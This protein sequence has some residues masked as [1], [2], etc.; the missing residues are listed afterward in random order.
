M[1]LLGFICIHTGYNWTGSNLC[2][3]FL[4]RNGIGLRLEL[5]DSTMPHLGIFGWNT[6]GV[7]GWRGDFYTLSVLSDHIDWIE[8]NITD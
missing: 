6:E 3:L 4:G 8:L 7:L 1:S 5:L 2:V